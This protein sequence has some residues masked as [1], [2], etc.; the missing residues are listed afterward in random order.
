[1]ARR[2]PGRRSAA[3]IGQAGRVH[4]Q[5]PSGCHHPYITRRL[6][7]GR[8]P[9]VTRPACRPCR[10][11]RTTGPRAAVP[12]RTAAITASHMPQLGRDVGVHAEHVDA[13]TDRPHAGRVESVGVGHRPHRHRVADHQAVEPELGAQEVG[14][15]P[16]AECR[17]V[18]VERTEDDVGGEDTVDAGRHR[19]TE[20]HQVRLQ[21]AV[22]VR[23][24]EVRV[25]GGVAVPGEVLGAGDHAGAVQA[26][27]VCDPRAAPPV[28]GP[29]RTTGCR[30]PGS[31]R[32]C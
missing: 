3:L 9:A 26:A 19:R 17:R 4:H 29:S 2:A 25:D 12:D 23:Q 28:A 11:P 7:T 32:W 10:P 31:R 30:S 18:V 27:H 14:D 8:A 16:A 22:D 21:I 20:R 13:G 15:D 6:S 24:A 1:M 5:C